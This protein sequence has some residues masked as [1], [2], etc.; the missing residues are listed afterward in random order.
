MKWQGSVGVAQSDWFYIQALE[1]VD[2]K[3]LSSFLIKMQY[4]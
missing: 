3:S 2:E 1:R 4:F